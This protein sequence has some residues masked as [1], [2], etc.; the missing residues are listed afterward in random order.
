MKKSSVRDQGALTRIC[1][2]LYQSPSLNFISRFLLRGGFD[3]CKT[4][5]CR[6]FFGFESLCKVIREELYQ[7]RTCNKNSGLSGEKNRALSWDLGA[8]NLSKSRCD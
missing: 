7:V 2:A 8:S 6:T 1:K 3:L 5:R 4:S